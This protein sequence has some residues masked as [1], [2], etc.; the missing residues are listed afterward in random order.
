[1]FDLKICNKCGEAKKLNEFSKN[2][3]KYRGNCKMCGAQNHRERYWAVDG[4]RDREIAYQ[5]A[6]KR[7]SRNEK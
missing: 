5:Q 3:D 6:K 2:R 7:Y 1:M 4:V